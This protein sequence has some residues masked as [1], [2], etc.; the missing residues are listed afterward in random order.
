MK[1]LCRQATAAVLI[2][3][4]W[5]HVCFTAPKT[6][7]PKPPAAVAA[8][9]PAAASSIGDT[10]LRTFN[11]LFYD[12]QAAGDFILAEVKPNF[13]VQTRQVSG[14]PAW[15]DATVNKAVAARFG[16]TEVAI[17]LASREGNQT[18]RIHVDGR[19][20]AV[21]DGTTLELPDGVGIRRQGNVYQIASESG[22]SVR[23]EINPTWINVY[24]GL[25]RFG[26]SVVHG[27]TA[28]VNGNANQIETRD[29]FVLT[30][31]FNFEELY[32]RYADSWR[33]SAEK[34][35][36]SV[37]NADTEIEGRTP[38]HAFYA[39]DLEPALR[40]SA[41]GVC[42]TAG[43]KAGPLLEACTLDVAV[44]GQDA[45]AKAFVNAIPPAIV[46]T[47]AAG[48]V[49][50]VILEHRKIGWMFLPLAVIL[51]AWFFMRRDVG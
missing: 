8:E 14:A 20:T 13:T 30:N 40:E 23:A 9:A 21:E 2:G 18:P 48:G 5:P 37:C 41:Q 31:A 1:R 42:T 22:D 17:C 3:L 29:H 33:V 34:S 32:H 50:G 11:G 47:L 46:G 24:V 44:L 36:L 15:P 27:L 39:K 12:F 51:I 16:R 7:A 4:L 28:N 35:L 49:I 43:V 45:A 10:H 25:G 38:T 26:S 19:L 6:P